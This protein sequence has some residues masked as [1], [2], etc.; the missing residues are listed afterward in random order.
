MTPTSPRIALPAAIVLSTVLSAQDQLPRVEQE[1]A[2]VAPVIDLRQQTH[3]NP[4]L[5]NREEKTAALI[6]ILDYARHK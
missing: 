1:T 4:K 6:V 5:S 3:Q 2:K